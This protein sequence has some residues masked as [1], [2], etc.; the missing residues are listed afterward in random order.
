M[1]AHESQSRIWENQIA[2]SRAFW[3]YWEPEY[4]AKFPKSLNDVPSD[5]LYRSINRVSLTQIRVDSDEVT[6]NLHIILRYEIERALF[7]GDLD[8]GDAPD[9][10]RE[11]AR[12]FLGQ[13]PETDKEGILQDIHWAHGAFGYFPSY[14]LGNLLAAQLWETLRGDL[15]EWEDD[16]R[17]GD[18]QQILRWLRERV[19]S[20]GKRR[21]L[22]SL[23]RSATGKELDGDALIAYLNDRYLQLFLSG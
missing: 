23:A 7:S 11:L 3:D 12:E 6:Y 10:W 5:T 15:P 20:V 4:R 19:H 16:L 8:V 18:T 14:C 22:W 9:R 1:A 21:D 13:E 17:K 2:R